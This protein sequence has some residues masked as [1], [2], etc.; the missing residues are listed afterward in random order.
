MKKT[1]VKRMF[2]ALA[3]VNYGLT[4]NQLE[5][6]I[7]DNED[8][9]FVDLAVLRSTISNALAEG[10]LVVDGKEP[11]HHCNAKYRRYKRTE[12]GMLK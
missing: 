1:L 8:G 4:S 9:F 10:W 7:N 6:A 2:S 3:D 12:K 5:A 11:C